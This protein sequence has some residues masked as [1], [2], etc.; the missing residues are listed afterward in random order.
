[1]LAVDPGKSTGWCVFKEGVLR[2]TGICRSV[3]EFD[4]K[5]DHLEEEYGKPDLLVVEHFYLFKH[6]AQQQSG[7]TFEAV[8]V[9]G[10]LKRQARKWGAEFVTQNSSILPI[11]VKWSKVAMPSNHKNSHWISAYNHGIYYLV[12]NGM[13][14]PTGME[15]PNAP[16]EA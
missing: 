11:A 15:S 14:L 10:M 3:E 5:I 1:M 7:S 13:A 12:K 16:K 9:I 4:E 2:D 6:K 8:Q